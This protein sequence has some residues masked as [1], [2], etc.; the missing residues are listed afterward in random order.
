MVTLTET[1]PNTS[2]FSGSIATALGAPVGGDG[3]LQLAQGDIISAT[4]HDADDGTGAPAIAFDSSDADCSGPTFTNVRVTDITD[5]S[6]IVR[7][8]TSEPSDSRVD[9]GTTAAL[10]SVVT[11]PALVTSHA[12]TI[13]N[14]AECARIHFRVTSTDV[15]GNARVVDFSGTPFQLSAYRIPG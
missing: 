8:N 13:G 1:G 4:Y 3:L 12:L 10:G 7:W 2:R 5:D 6:A 11:D 9:W 14:F 15:F